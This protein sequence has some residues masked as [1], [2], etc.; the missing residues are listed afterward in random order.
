MAQE[1]EHSEPEQRIVELLSEARA[2]TRAPASLRA[3]V[4]AMRA[5]GVIRPRLAGRFGA[6]VSGA[7]ATAVVASAVVVAVF[8]STAAPS[9]AAVTALAGRGPA[10]PAPGPDLAHP[11]A[12]LSA[13]VG[14]LRF[15]NWEGQGGWAAT[16]ERTDSVSGRQVVTVYYTHAGTQ[17]IYS[18]VAAPAITSS[19]SGN[20]PYL[21]QR[22]GARISVI[23]TEFG[24]TCV[25]TAKG[26]S[27]SALWRLAGASRE[28]A[29]RWLSR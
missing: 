18:I 3:S 28:H 2:Q 17:L 13:R 15:P 4:A 7:A 20:D 24:H 16:G 26:M 19:T 8:T 25:L 5:P 27:V 1:Q 22:K 10:G 12:L 14:D 6:A 9:L 23:W 29:S 21:V 11:R